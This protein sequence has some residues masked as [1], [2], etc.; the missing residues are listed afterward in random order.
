MSCRRSFGWKA[1]LMTGCLTLAA[2][3]GG[4]EE[5]DAKPLNVYTDKGQIVMRYIDLVEGT[6]PPVKKQDAILVH[7]TGWVGTEKFDSSRDSGKAFPVVIG[8][9]QVI[10]GWDEGILGMKKGGKRKLFIPAA[11]GYGD[12]GVKGTP[13]KPGSKLVFEVEL[14]EI[15]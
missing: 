10:K 7:Y 5:D 11:L 2:G 14:L 8:T 9:G 13:I 15:K 6:G 4:D 1:L 3:C 12:K